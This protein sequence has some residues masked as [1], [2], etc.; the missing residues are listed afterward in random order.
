[1]AKNQKIEVK[2]NEIT[3]FSS[4]HSE[5]I[6]LTDMARYRDTD[7]TNYIIQNWNILP[8]HPKNIRFLN[9]KYQSKFGKV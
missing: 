6:S 1:M 2:G 7:R 8:F 3:L 4:Q 9:M 5:Y